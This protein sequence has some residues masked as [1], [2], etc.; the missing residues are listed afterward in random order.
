[1]PRAT[2]PP[3]H[4]IVK[5]AAVVI[6]LVAAVAG[7]L[8]GSIGLLPKPQP[9]PAADAAMAGVLPAA[10][11]L[12]HSHAQADAGAQLF[13][14]RCAGCHTVGGGARKSGPDLAEA[15]LRRDLTWV[16]AMVAAPDSMF[17]TDSLA[18]WVLQVHGMKPDQL[19]E[20]DPD[21]RALA[22]FFRSFDLAR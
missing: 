16:R 21:L 19:A 10:D 11:T 5:A 13:E 6:V 22:A 12:D 15:A 3:A 7:A 8:A 17:R 2:T 14:Q 1:M 20:D 18:R 4:P 9:V